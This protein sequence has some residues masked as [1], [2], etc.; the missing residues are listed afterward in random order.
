MAQARRIIR[1]R[2]D[3]LCGARYAGDGAALP[4]RASHSADHRRDLCGSW[5]HVGIPGLCLG[6]GWR[7]CAAYGYWRTIGERHRIGIV[8]AA[9]GGAECRHGCKHLQ[10][11]TSVRQCAA[12]TPHDVVP[13]NR[14]SSIQRAGASG[15][16]HHVH[17]R[18]CTRT[19]ESD[20]RTTGRCYLA[21]VG[22][23][24]LPRG[25]RL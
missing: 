10:M 3:G 24:H 20:G 23:E 13:G 5:R 19:A 6:P 14:Q 15:L 11:D 2:N 22:C 21:V 9:G 18:C 12:P 4:E 16:S 17:H 1:L 25:H 8:P 7:W